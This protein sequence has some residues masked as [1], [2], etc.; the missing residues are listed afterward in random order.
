MVT[1]EPRCKVCSSPN[2]NFYEQRFLEDEDKVTWNDLAEQA[3]L[4]E[5]ISYKAFERHFKKHFSA[6]SK[7]IH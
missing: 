7:G 2:R 3:V 5:E 1:F 6:K 4:G